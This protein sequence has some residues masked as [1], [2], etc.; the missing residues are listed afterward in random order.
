MRDRAE[1][2]ELMAGWLSDERVLEFWDGRDHP[3]T[4][5]SARAKYGPSIRGHDPTTSCIIELEGSAI[6]YLQFYRTDDWPEWRTTIGLEPDPRRYAV[7]LF[8]GQPERW[9]HGLGTRAL[10]AVVRHLLETVG[11]SEVVIT[12]FVRNVRAIRSY[13]KAGFRKLRLMPEVEE[14]EGT[15][16]DEWLMS[17]RPGA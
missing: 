4:V 2:Y 13:E 6:G 7:D 10:R 1:D 5:E 3:M 17:I 9:G 8:L 12:P 15:L 16:Q 14:H 11:A